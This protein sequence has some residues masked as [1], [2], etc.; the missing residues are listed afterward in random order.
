MSEIIETFID[1]VYHR[2][3][4]SDKENQNDLFILLHGWLGNEKSMS[5]FASVIPTNSTIIYP[6]G[7]TKVGEDQYGWVDIN[8]SSSDFFD[9]AESSKVLFKSIN[10]LLK[11]FELDNPKKKINLIGFSQGAAMCAVLSLLFPKSFNKI[12]ILAG[13]LPKNQ[14]EKLSDNLAPIEYYIAHGKDDQLVSFDKSIELRD[15]LLRR[16]AKVQFCE[17]DIGHKVGKNCLKNLKN[18]FSS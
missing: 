5:I 4:I 16:Q 3:D 17:E 7:I 1:P 12:A 2:L 9:Y 6:R 15:F 11:S 14:P 10:E 8:K 13:F 18:F